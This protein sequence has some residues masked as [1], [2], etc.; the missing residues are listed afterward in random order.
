MT[1]LWC[2]SRGFALGLFVSTTR[3]YAFELSL[4]YVVWPWATILHFA[5][6]GLAT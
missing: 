5:N 4:A 6:R 2:F 1:F 3:N